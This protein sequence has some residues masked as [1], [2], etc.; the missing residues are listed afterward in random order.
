MMERKDI[1]SK[2]KAQQEELQKLGVKSLCL[3]GSVARDEATQNSDVDLLVE[4][5]RPAGLFK[6]SKVE[7]YLE[8]SLGCAVDLGTKS[9]LREHCRPTVIKDLIQIF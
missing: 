9:A 3:F 8:E 1:I 2:I 4:L 5:E 7:H 6:L